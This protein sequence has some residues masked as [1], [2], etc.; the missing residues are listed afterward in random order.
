MV[1]D[2][3]IEFAKMTGLSP[4]NSRPREHRMTVSKR[5]EHTIE[6]INQRVKNTVDRQGRL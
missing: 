3:M 5:L 1:H 4:E 2:I 6:I